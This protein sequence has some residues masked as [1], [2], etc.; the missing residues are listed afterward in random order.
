MYP[1]EDGA[2][3]AITLNITFIILSN[4]SDWYSQKGCQAIISYKL[5]W[6]KVSI[7]VCMDNYD[8]YKIQ[9]HIYNILFVYCDIGERAFPLYVYIRIN[10]SWHFTKVPPRQ[11]E[12]SASRKAYFTVLGVGK[13]FSKDD[14]TQ[15][16]E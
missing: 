14:P 5:W 1:S 16:I 7:H 11:R 13:I 15:Y 10:D 9:V 8:V 6:S 12:S 2:I 4:G 3:Q